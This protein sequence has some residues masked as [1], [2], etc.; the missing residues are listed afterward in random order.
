MDVKVTL[1]QAVWLDKSGGFRVAGTVAR[2]EEK[3]I[4]L[5]QKHISVKNGAKLHYVDK[6]D[7]WED[8]IK[9]FEAQK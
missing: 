8:N 1:Y 7:D 4:K 9:C 3:T 6:W 5:S 2:T